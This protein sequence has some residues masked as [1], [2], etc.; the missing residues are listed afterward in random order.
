MFPM[1]SLSVSVIF[2]YYILKAF[3]TQ[4][5]YIFQIFTEEEILNLENLLK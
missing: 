1:M 4:N 5:D 2:S 3:S